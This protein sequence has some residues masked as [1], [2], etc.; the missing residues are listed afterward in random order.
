MSETDTIRLKNG[1][2][3][4]RGEAE[5]ILETVGKLNP[6]FTI[7]KKK[8]MIDGMLFFFG[9]LFVAYYLVT[10]EGAILLYVGLFSAITGLHGLQRYL[11]LH[12]ELRELRS[13]VGEDELRE[14]VD[15]LRGFVG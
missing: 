12:K 15:E 6:D 1:L 4:K 13:R 2:E 5:R 14:I 10:G 11:E 9:P 3:I 7:R 8:L